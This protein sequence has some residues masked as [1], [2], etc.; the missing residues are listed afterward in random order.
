MLAKAV[1]GEET[2]TIVMEIDMSFG[3]EVGVRSLGNWE[4]GSPLS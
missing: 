1:V 2:V 3:R 4:A